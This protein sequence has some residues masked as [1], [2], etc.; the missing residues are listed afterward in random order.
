MT[1]NHESPSSSV[2][3][4]G[5]ALWKVMGSIP[6]GDRDFF[7]VPQLRQSEYSIFYLFTCCSSHPSHVFRFCGNIS[8]STGHHTLRG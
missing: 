2:V 7:F 8:Q 1:A 4:V 3:S 5:P 6:I